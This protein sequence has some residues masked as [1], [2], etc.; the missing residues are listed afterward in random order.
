MHFI[1]FL[2]YL[3]WVIRQ[4]KP[5]E[6]FDSFGRFYA[7]LKNFYINV[8]ITMDKRILPFNNIG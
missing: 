1:L 6:D 7:F 4:S 3:G 8:F 5:P 2:A